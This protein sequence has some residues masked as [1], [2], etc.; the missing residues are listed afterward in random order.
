[1]RH[2]R[3]MTLRLD[4]RH[5][6]VWRSPDSIQVG[7][8]RPLVVI[9][10]V[11]DGLERMLAA[12]FVGVPRSGA[13]MIGREGGA[14]DEAILDL[15]GALRP[16]LLVTDESLPVSATDTGACRRAVAPSAYKPLM[17]VLVAFF[18]SKL[19]YAPLL[20]CAG[21]AEPLP[22]APGPG[23]VLPLAHALLHDMEGAQP[24]RHAAG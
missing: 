20:L 18:L 9:T 4:P 21:A 22:R 1:M 7:I 23:G 12:L 19:L 16:A 15:L 11:S 13:L 3:R 8:D 2:H 5:P 10:A 6:V 17:A 14:S 24:V